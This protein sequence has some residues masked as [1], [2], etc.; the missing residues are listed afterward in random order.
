M[1]TI[2]S[3]IVL[4]ST[5]LRHKVRFP[6]DRQVAIAVHWQVQPGTEE[7]RVIQHHTLLLSHTDL[8]EP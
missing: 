4:A 8:S 7:A 1:P 5:N 2:Y 3:D 6:Q